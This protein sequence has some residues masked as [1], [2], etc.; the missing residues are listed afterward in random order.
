MKTNKE[1]HK[2][3]DTSKEHV[4]MILDDPY[5]ESQDANAEQIRKSV[6]KWYEKVEKK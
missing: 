2:N 5:D 4:L 3:K 6:L 1:F